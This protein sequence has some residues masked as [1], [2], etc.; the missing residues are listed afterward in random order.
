MDAN[1]FLTDKYNREPTDQ[2]IADYMKVSKKHIGKIR[3]SSNAV[4]TGSFS[5]EDAEGSE[6]MV[7]PG[8][9]SG[10]LP[11]DLL[12][13]YVLS[14]IEGDPI[15]QSIYEYDN[16]LNGKKPI[17]VVEL[18]KKLNVSPGTISNKRKSINE[19]SFNAEKVLLK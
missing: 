3:N 11:K 1:F 14:G 16:S 13:M 7:N 18:A 19:L 6:S 8:V 10:A 5:R 9:E 4:N 2:E 17:G 15:A 12:D